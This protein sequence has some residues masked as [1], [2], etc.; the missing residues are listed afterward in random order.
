[1]ASQGW[2]ADLASHMDSSDDNSGWLERH[3]LFRQNY[4]ASKDYRKNGAT[5]MGR[6]LHHLGKNKIKKPNRIVKVKL[7]LKFEKCLIIY[8]FS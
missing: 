5:F 4:D 6:V 7:K 3:L 1:M 2:Y 8:Y